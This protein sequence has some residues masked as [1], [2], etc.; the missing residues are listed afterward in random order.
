MK[1]L[2]LPS[3]LSILLLG[4]CATQTGTETVE[5]AVSFASFDVYG[6]DFDQADSVPVQALAEAP[7]D[8]MGSTVKVSGTI[9]EV[10]Q[11]MGCWMTLQVSDTQ[12]VRIV[13]P[14][15]ESDNYLFTLAKDIGGRRAMVQGTLGQSTLAEFEAPM[16]TDGEDHHAGE[17][18]EDHH[19][20]EDHEEAV[21]AG[22]ELHI[23]ASGVLVEKPADAGATAP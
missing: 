6:A 15:D 11:G 1:R 14:R 19:E 23:T 8:H 21:P 22:L 18:G 20:G 13:M 17:E 4:G 5:P 16:H 7:M 9:V 10:C 3:L 12:L 2:F